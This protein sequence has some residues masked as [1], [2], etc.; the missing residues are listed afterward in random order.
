VIDLSLPKTNNEGKGKLHGSTKITLHASPASTMGCPVS[1]LMRQSQ[2]QSSSPKSLPKLVLTRRISIPANDCMS[3]D[4]AARRNRCYHLQCDH[5]LT[6]SRP[7]QLC[8]SSFGIGRRTSS[9]LAGYGIDGTLRCPIE[10]RWCHDVR[11]RNATS[12]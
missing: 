6:S 3:G 9:C 5:C 2:S 10:P 12:V 1:Q 7:S 8:T 11:V 4:A